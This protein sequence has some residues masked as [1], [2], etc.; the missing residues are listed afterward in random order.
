MGYLGYVC[1]FGNWILAHSCHFLSQYSWFLKACCYEM[2]TG[3]VNGFYVSIDRCSQQLFCSCSYRVQS[4]AFKFRDVTI[5]FSPP[6]P[7]ECR[8]HLI[9]IQIGSHYHSHSFLVLHA[10]HGGILCVTF[11]TARDYN[12]WSVQSAQITLRQAFM[13]FKILF[14]SFLSSYFRSYCGNYIRSIMFIGIH[15]PC[16]LSL[17]YHHRCKLY[18]STT[19]SHSQTLYKCLVWIFN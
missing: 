13:Q 1:Y 5:I 15:A 4:E 12:D 3:F 9:A 16:E 11:S 18:F 14:V 19:P 8:C 6:S 10:V 2:K 7:P 17:F